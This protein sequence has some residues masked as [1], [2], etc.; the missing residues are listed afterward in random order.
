MPCCG[1]KLLL[2]GIAALSLLTAA[3]VAAE[4]LSKNLAY[5]V[6]TAYTLY[7]RLQHCYSYNIDMERAEAAAAA[8][9]DKAKSEAPSIDTSY[10]WRS[11]QRNFYWQADSTS[12][13]T[14]YQNLLDIAGG[15]EFN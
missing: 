8:I 1:Q 7:G 13:Q 4:P 5:R 6:I 12:C 9:V 10:L 14:Y 3:E 15:A 11:A 2:P